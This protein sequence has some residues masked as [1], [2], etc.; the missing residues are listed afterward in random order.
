MTPQDSATISDKYTPYGYGFENLAPGPGAIALNMSVRWNMPATGF[1]FVR[2]PVRGWHERASDL[3]RGI[4]R[5]W[6]LGCS[7]DGMVLLVD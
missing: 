1:Q 7:A 4:A 5:R 6:R 3:G 2:R